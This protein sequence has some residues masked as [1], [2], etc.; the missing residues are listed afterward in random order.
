MCFSKILKKKQKKKQVT[1]S[2]TPSNV[3]PIDKLQLWLQTKKNEING[4]EKQIF[5]LINQRSN[6]FINEIQEQIKTLENIDFQKIDADERLKKIVNE[7]LTKYLNYVENLIRN[8][9]SLNQQENLETFVSW[10]NKTFFEFEKKSYMDYQRAIYL[11]KKELFDIRKTISDFSKALSEIVDDNKDI[12]DLSRNIEDI[13]NKLNQYHNINKTIIETQEKT[14]QLTQKLKQEEDII[15]MKLKEIDDTKQDKEYL[16]Q[17]KQKEEIQS[18]EYNLEKDVYSLKTMIDFK[19]LT[20][21]YHSDPK[22]MEIIKNY[23][24]RFEEYFLTND[25]SDFFK[26]IEDSKLNTPEFDIKRKEITTRK[27]E[28]TQMK[29]NIPKDKLQD[30]EREK[31]QLE[32]EISNLNDEISKEY[33]KLEKLNLIKIEL[34]DSIKQNMS[35]FNIL[36]TN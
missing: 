8:I 31:S 1:V 25:C 29:K 28:L 35:N 9:Q 20:N 32:I 18:Y 36:I 4:R 16:A 17:L 21:I 23:K 27:Q 14:N 26:I 10:I 22:K 2:S 13:E 15:A 3:I 11:I 6:E 30:L 34:L 19:N 33:Q 5:S 12:I 24:E 7:N